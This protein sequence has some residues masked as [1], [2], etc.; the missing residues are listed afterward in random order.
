MSE[1]ASPQLES[2][3]MREALR[4]FL[5]RNSATPG[6]VELH[7]DDSLLELGVID[8]VAMLGLLEHLEKDYGIVVDQD[9][10]IPEHF[11]SLSAILEFVQRKRG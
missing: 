11:G 4:Q 2:G 1:D 3:V 10:M 9:E 7:D 6:I 8:S 5:L